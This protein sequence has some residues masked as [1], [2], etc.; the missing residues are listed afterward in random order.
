VKHK[1]VLPLVLLG[2]LT[3]GVA[4]LIGCK[5]G[6]GQRCQVN[7]DCDTGLVCNQATDPPTCQ[8]SGS[9]DPIDASVPEASVD[10]PTD[11]TDA[12]TD[13]ATDATDAMPDA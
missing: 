6:E 2:F 10:A 9:F 8:S 7:D 3:G 11:T 4:L 5:Q 1:L 13:G 12:P